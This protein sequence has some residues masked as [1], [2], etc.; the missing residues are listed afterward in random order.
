MSRFVIILKKYIG[1][2][3]LSLILGFFLLSQHIPF[4]FDGIPDM[5]ADEVK[6]EYQNIYNHPFHS[7]VVMNGTKEQIEI[8][9]AFLN[10]LT[11][12]N[13]AYSYHDVGC[14]QYLSLIQKEGS[15]LTIMG[16]NAIPTN[17]N[18]I[19]LS[20]HNRQH[21]ERWKIYFTSEFT[22]EYFEWFKTLPNEVLME[23]ADQQK[24]ELE[25]RKKLEDYGK[26]QLSE[27]IY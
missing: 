2:V 19:T 18:S 14:R 26:N 11:P 20:Y 25:L 23:I 9:L 13:K 22:Q 12:R 15:Y 16:C 1:F 27:V 3:I 24:A 5:S 6:M 4:F 10:T 21:E 7:E 17:H 8:V